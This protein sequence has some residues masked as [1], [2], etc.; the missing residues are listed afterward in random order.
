MEKMAA[1]KKTV[2]RAAPSPAIPTEKDQGYDASHGY[3]EGHGGPS[4]PGDAPAEPDSPQTHLPTGE[5]DEKDP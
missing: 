2:P 1:A 3:G 5:D 4:G